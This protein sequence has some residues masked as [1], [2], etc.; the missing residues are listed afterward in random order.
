M[1]TLCTEIAMNSNQKYQLSNHY[2]ITV[3]VVEEKKPKP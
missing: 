1:V 3:E 2:L